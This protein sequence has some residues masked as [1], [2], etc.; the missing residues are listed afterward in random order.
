[1]HPSLK[2]LKKKYLPVLCMCLYENK[3]CKSCVFPLILGGLSYGVSVR[4]YVP[5]IIV[6]VQGERGK[7]VNN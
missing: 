6:V 1:M 2:C 4:L 5:H 7:K 3:I